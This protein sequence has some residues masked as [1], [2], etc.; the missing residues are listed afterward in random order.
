[1]PPPRWSRAGTPASASGTPCCLPG[2]RI[3]RDPGSPAAR[4]LPERSSVHLVHGHAAADPFSVYAPLFAA[5]AGRAVDRG[6]IDF[7]VHVH[8][9]DASTQSAWGSPPS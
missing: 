7:V 3:R 5:L 9:G 8:V 4:W 6:I 2:S 1:M